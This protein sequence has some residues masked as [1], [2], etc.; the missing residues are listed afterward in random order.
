MVG[1]LSPAEEFDFAEGTCRP[2][3]SPYLTIQNP[4]GTEAQVIITYMR[5]DGT[6]QQQA[7]VVPAHSRVTVNVTDVRGSG[8]GPS[9]DFSATVASQH[10]QRGHRRLAPHVLQLSGS[11]DRGV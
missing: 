10:Q 5:G 1:A 8:D 9:Y 6:N 7:L 4:A 3:Y 11:M 2:G